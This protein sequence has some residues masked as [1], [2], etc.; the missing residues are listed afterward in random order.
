VLIHNL[1]EREGD[2]GL[3]LFAPLLFAEQQRCVVSGGD[4]TFCSMIEGREPDVEGA[5]FVVDEGSRHGLIP[6]DE[7]EASLENCNGLVARLEKNNRQAAPVEI[8][9]D[10]A[11]SFGTQTT[12]APESEPELCYAT[13]AS[14]TASDD[15][16]ETCQLEVEAEPAG[17]VEACPRVL[18][19]G[20]MR[21]IHAA[22]PPSL[23]TLRWGRAFA[24]G[25]HGDSFVSL[26]NRSAPHRH[27]LVVIRTTAGH[28]LGGFASEAWRIQEGFQNRHAYYGTGQSFLFCSHPDLSPS[29]I[30][31]GTSTGGE[32]QRNGEGAPLHLYPW[33]GTNDYCQI[34]DVDKRT[35]CMGGAGDFGFIVQDDFVRGETGPCGTFGNPALVP[36]G[37]FEV[38]EFEIYGLAPLHAVSPAS[39]L[40]P[41]SPFA[42]TPL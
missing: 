9:T 16:A 18:S 22:L 21:Q 8:S 28:V 29:T 27:T 23:R 32:D 10:A 13:D 35:L 25:L 7:E 15:D 42:G 5:P 24:I 6:S 26:L 11:L 33:T 31:E 2:F 36:G 1:R 40:L 37:S 19:A 3:S 20:Q 38:A 17:D 14:T 30:T 4:G 39:S 41:T 34:C 12:A